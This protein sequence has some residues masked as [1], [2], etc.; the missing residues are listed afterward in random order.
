MASTTNTAQSVEPLLKESYSDGKKK[1]KKE[2]F[3]KIKSM[4]KCGK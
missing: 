4:C 3:E 2:K 1:K